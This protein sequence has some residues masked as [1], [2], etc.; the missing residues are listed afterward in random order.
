MF[1]LYYIAQYAVAPV[2]GFD[3]SVI[4]ASTDYNVK[5]YPSVANIVDFLRCSITY[6]NAAQMIHGLKSFINKINNN[7]IECLTGIVRIK[8]GFTNVL[9]WANAN[10]ADYCDIKLNII[11]NNKDNT[12]A[13]ICE[14]QFLVSFLLEAKKI[15]HK[16]SWCCVVC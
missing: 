15:G 5:N 3:R 1:I 12:R 7:E 9:H 16:L 2:K 4:K 13:M 11:Y 14:L 6:P 10:D 8:N